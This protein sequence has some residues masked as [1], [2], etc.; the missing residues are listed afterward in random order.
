MSVETIAMIG[1]P[2]AV[3][4]LYCGA[5]WW[6]S[7]R[8]V[9]A[10]QFFRGGGKAG[11]A[12]GMWVLVF[13]AAITWVFAKSIA[14]AAILGQAFGFLGGVGYATYYLSFLVAAVAIYRKSVV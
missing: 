6:I 5:V 13:S 9:S 4:A 7:P 3:L 8:G 12:P 2:W 11:G 14:N 1:A 10:A